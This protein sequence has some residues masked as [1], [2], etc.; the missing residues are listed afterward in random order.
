M[1]TNNALK[2]LEHGRK[3]KGV[4][5]PLL[6]DFMLKPVNIESD[7]DVQFLTDLFQTMAERENRR[8]SDRMF[9]PSALASCLRQVYLLKHHDD[10]D[11]PKLSP[12]KREPNFYFLNGNFLHVKWQFA[13]YKMEKAIDDPKVFH[14][15]GFEVPIK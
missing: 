6:E 12:V 13:L 4:L 9:S 15:I 5:V 1:S 10:L 7:E 3:R 14:I 2:L 11:I 8:S